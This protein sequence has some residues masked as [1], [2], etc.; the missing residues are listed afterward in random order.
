MDKIINK[1]GY[2]GFVIKTLL[3]DDLYSC[4][5]EPNIKEMDL[6]PCHQQ[7]KAEKKAEEEI[8]KYLEN[9]SKI[10]R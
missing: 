6:Y 1:Y 10:C 8:D 2:C 5:I 7:H 4:I 9:N 3:L